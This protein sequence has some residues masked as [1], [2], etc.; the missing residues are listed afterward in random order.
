MAINMPQYGT[1]RTGDPGSIGG[2]SGG[3]SLI[4]LAGAAGGGSAGGAMLGG[5]TAGIGGLMQRAEESRAADAAQ[6]RAIS[7]MDLELKKK[8][9]MNSMEMA[10]KM[11]MHEA[12]LDEFAL[13]KQQYGLM[14]NRDNARFNREDLKA[15]EKKKLST[16]ASSFYN[17]SQRN[18]SAVEQVI[19]AATDAGVQPEELLARWG[20]E[21]GFSTDL[22]LKGEAL[23]KNRG[24]AVGP[25]QIVPSMHP[26]V[27]NAKTLYDQALLAAKLGKELGRT[28]YYGTGKAPAGHPTPEQYGRNLDIYQSAITDTLSQIYSD[29]AKRANAVET[30]QSKEQMKMAGLMG[31]QSAEAP[32]IQRGTITGTAAQTPAWQTPPAPAKR[33]TL[34]ELKTLGRPAVEA[35]LIR[36]IKNSSDP[37]YKGMTDQQ[38]RARAARIAAEI[39]AQ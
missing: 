12:G 23:S 6:A 4:Q 30:A 15:D 26:E 25:F 27:V 35:N 21:G 31:D 36:T 17:V 38:V 3:N 33:S 8:A 16:A 9:A 19:K 29:T 22:G 5:L 13:Q 1:I 37:K 18:P 34:D 32:N 20:V 11:M 7:A 24:N 14:E 39:F 2:P 10:N 28:G